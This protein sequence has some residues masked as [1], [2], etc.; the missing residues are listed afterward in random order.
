MN[1]S[2]E[3]YKT[4]DNEWRCSLCTEKVSRNQGQCFN[5]KLELKFPIDDTDYKVDTGVDDRTETLIIDPKEINGTI[6]VH[7]VDLDK[8]L[9]EVNEIRGDIIFTGIFGTELEKTLDDVVELIENL[10][11]K[12][13]GKSNIIF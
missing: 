10:G 13:N 9:R 1:K 2:V 3:A 7:G 11:G 4:S 6:H 5:C 8:L 12:D